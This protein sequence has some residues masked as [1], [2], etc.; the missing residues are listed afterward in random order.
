MHH[1][2]LH[3]VH[4]NV[5]MSVCVVQVAVEPVGTPEGQR[6][7]DPQGLPRPYSP[8]IAHLGSSGQPWHELQEQPPPHSDTS[9]PWEDDDEPLRHWAGDSHLDAG[10]RDSS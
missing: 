7:S 3:T 4:C 9:D 10:R 1:W 2:A 6:R 5:V 8:P